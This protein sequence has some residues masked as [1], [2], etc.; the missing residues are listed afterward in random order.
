MDLRKR[1]IIGKVPPALFHLL[2]RGLDGNP[3]K[4]LVLD[5]LERAI[6]LDEVKAIPP[7]T[8]ESAAYTGSRPSSQ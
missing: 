8:A 2:A 4:L 7:G 5:I 6:V 3:A 1:A